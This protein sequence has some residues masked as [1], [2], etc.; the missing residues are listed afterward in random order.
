[1]DNAD[2]A[3]ELIDQRMQDALDARRASQQSEAM[4]GP[5]NCVE[6]DEPIPTARRL[7]VPGCRY[8]TECQAARE[9]R[10]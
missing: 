4:Q 10:R 7:S 9:G 5:A 8:C 1:M 2:R 6:C 3:Q